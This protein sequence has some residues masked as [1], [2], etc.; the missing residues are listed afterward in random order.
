[1][2]KPKFKEVKPFVTCHTAKTLWN[3][4]WSPGTLILG[5]VLFTIRGQVARGAHQSTKPENEK[6][7][8]ALRTWASGSFLLKDRRGWLAIEFRKLLG[9]GM[10][11]TTA[12]PNFGTRLGC[13]LRERPHRPSSCSPEP[14]SH[15]RV[16][17]T[18]GYKGPAREQT[19][20]A[21]KL[22]RCP[23]SNF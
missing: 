4:D 18:A 8:R 16:C 1:M 9:P 7:Q 14:H 11:G 3:L 15:S 2:R 12:N 19:G 13:L 10:M 17:D 5:P 22:P 20:K 21:S 6:P 23:R